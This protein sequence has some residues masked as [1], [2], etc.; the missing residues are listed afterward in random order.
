MAEAPNGQA[1]ADGAAGYTRRAHD[2][3]EGP[4]IR[5]ATEVI[6]VNSKEPDPHR[7]PD[8]LG[9]YLNDHL[10]GAS[11]GV[12]LARRLASNF[13]R[14]RHGRTLQGLAVDVEQDRNSLLDVMRRLDVSVNR[15]KVGAGWLAEK[16]GRLKLNKRLFRRSPLSGLVELEAMYL[17]VQGK[18]AGWLVLRRASQAYPNLDP[19]EFDVLIARAR[20]QEYKLEAIRR[21]VAERAVVSQSVAST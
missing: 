14:S 8:L 11:G 9:V 19:G 12:E 3:Q 17:G 18:A 1:F 20:Q 13:E 16:L 10:A 4:P 5:Q 2:R 7:N 6:R 21:D 15:F